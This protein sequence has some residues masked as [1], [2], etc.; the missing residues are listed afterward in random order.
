MHRFLCLIIVVLSVGFSGAVYAKTSD[1]NKTLDDIIQHRLPNEAVGVI[2][3]DAKTGDILYEH[4]SFQAFTPASNTKLLTTTAA[5]YALGPDFRF[6]TTAAINKKQLSKGVLQGNLGLIFTGDP[7]FTTQKLEELIRDVKRSGIN[8]IRGDIVIDDTAFSGPSYAAG[9]LEDDLAW[10]YAAPVTAVI[11]NQNANTYELVPSQ[12]LGGKT[13]LIAQHADDHIQIKSDIVTVTESAA[14]DHCTLMLHVDSDNT[15]HAAGCWPINT[16]AK[17]IRLAL[18]NS[19]AY[20]MAVIQEL[21]AKHNIS[22]QGKIVMGKTPKGL[23][24]IAS[25]SSWPLRDLIKT[26]L[27][28]SNNIYTESLTKTLGK[29]YYGEGS[30][31]NGTLAIRQI[32]SKKAGMN[33]N[34]AYLTDGSG[35]SRYNLITPREMMR[36]LYVIEH[37]PQLS[38]VIKPALPYAGKD[39]TLAH[40]MLS[41]DLTQHIRAKTGSMRG[42]CALSGYLTTKEGQDLIFTVMINQI[43]GKLQNAQAVQEEISSRL[44]MLG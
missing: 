9:W 43:V 3:A 22:L 18:G 1:L 28:D 5:L 32:L 8:T 10:Y 16:K 34:Q 40:R 17:T 13:K 15:I 20:A 14:E 2:V 29:Y 21:M 36:L 25:Q 30:F 44:Y 41:F 42:V 33:F 31:Q 12:T 7:S 4:Q 23:Q 24:V 37:T 11:L 35:L 38:S 39:G 26:V 19:T 6:K 27:E